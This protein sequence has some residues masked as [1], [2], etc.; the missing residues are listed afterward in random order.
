MN[1]AFRDTWTKLSPTERDVVTALSMVY[2]ERSVLDLSRLLNKI[3]LRPPVGENR[4]THADT[5]VIVHKLHELGIAVKH[6]DRSWRINTDVSEEIMRLAHRRPDFE[7]L[8]NEVRRELPYKTY[9]QPS[10][11]LALMREIRIAF[12]LQNESSF[13]RLQ[14]ETETFYPDKAKTGIF[15]DPL[16]G[17]FEPRWVEQLPPAWQEINVRKAFRQAIAEM[18]PLDSLVEFLEQHENIREESPDPYVS[19]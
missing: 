8:L 6:D 13:E 11:H 2:E 16:F 4:F 14:N 1:G 18:E 7:H 17:F 12:Y 10:S 5:E 19:Y 9:W 15:I 3:G